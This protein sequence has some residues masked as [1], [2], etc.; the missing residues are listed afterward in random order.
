[1]ETFSIFANSSLSS[2]EKFVERNIYLFDIGRVKLKK[3]MIVRLRGC[4][5]RLPCKED[6][7]VTTL[8]GLR[9]KPITQQD[10]LPK[11]EGLPTYLPGRTRCLCSDIPFVILLKQIIEALA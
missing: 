11:S 2:G 7:L 3:K 4:S 5:N 6:I 9:D 1:M 8:F 10:A